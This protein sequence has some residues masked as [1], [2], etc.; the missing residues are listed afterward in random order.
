[1]SNNGKHRKDGRLVDWC[2]RFR[3]CPGPRSP[4][5]SQK[6]TRSP[7]SRPDRD[8]FFQLRAGIRCGPLKSVL[9]V[10][11]LRCGIDS[12]RRRA[13]ERYQTDLAM[14]AVTQKGST[15]SFCWGIRAA[16]IISKSLGPL[17]SKNGDQRGA[18]ASGVFRLSAGT[19]PSSSACSGDRRDSR[20]TSL[21]VHRTSGNP[22][23]RTPW[24]PT[25]APPPP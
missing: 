21:P 1:M 20:A 16:A 23:V 13:A 9:A 5:L 11:E 2:T 22:P 25:P 7:T 4:P 24:A 17:A 3:N 15:V 12:V 18:R 19:F 14:S 10:D 8:F 6:A